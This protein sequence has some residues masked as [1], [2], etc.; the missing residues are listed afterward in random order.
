MIPPSPLS[1]SCFLQSPWRQHPSHHCRGDRGQ[2]PGGGGGGGGGWFGQARA[3]RPDGGVGGDSRC[4]AQ[5]GAHA[6]VSEGA[7]AAFRVSRMLLA[8]RGSAALFTPSEEICEHLTFALHADLATAHE[9]VVVCD[10]TI[11]VFCHL[12]KDTEV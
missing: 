12:E 5:P 9:V 11:N 3:R 4:G 10:E 8:V 1:F 2:V 6:A 7:R